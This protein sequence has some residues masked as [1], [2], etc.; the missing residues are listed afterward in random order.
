MREDVTPERLAILM[1]ALSASA[2]R[3]MEFRVCMVGGG[4][5]ILRGWRGFFPGRAPGDTR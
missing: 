2:P 4:T 5:A 3:G 1:Q